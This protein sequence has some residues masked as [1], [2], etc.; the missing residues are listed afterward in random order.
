MTDEHKDLFKVIRQNKQYEKNYRSMLN[1][2]VWMKNE[3][4]VLFSDGSLLGVNDR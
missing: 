1:F 3:G 2:G 4:K